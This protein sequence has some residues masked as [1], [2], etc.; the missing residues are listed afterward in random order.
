MKKYKLK[1]IF[2]SAIAVCCIVGCDYDLAPIKSAAAYPPDLNK[3]S[4]FRAFSPDSGGLATQLVL[5]GEN[6][7]TDTSYVK[8]TVNN[9]NAR[10][11]GVNDTI[12]YAVVPARADT[13]YI[14][15]YIGKAEAKKKYTSGKEFIYQFKR[16]VTT[17]VGQHNQE[18]RDDGGYAS[19]KLRRPWFLLTDK[20]G[21]IFFVDE[22]RG[23]SANGALRRAYQ[24]NVETLLQN[25]EGPFQSPTC[26]AFSPRQDTLYITNY[27]YPSDANDVKTDFNII[28]V[29]RDGGF[30]DV[31]GLCKGAKVGTQGIAVHPKTG[32]I[33]F[34]NK[35]DGYIYRYDGPGFNDVTPLFQ[36]N[37]GARETEMRLLFNK[38]GTELY[39]SVRNRHCIQKVP[40]NAVTHEF[41][42]AKMLAGE[43]DVPGYASGK[44]PAARFDNPGQPVLDEDGNLIVPD[45]FN[46]CIRKI[47]PDGDVTLYA[48]LPKQ[49]G[50]GDGLPEQAKFNQPEAITLYTDHTLYVTDRDNHVIRRIAI[51]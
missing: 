41:G 29:T 15:L 10:V 25:T 49:W 21:A 19:S 48:G 27:S 42:D 14:D 43:W 4:V 47:T 12:I 45:K 35:V 18:G 32:E 13:G 22:G 2:L 1:L 3:E 30:M 26:L 33:F 11:I 6:F 46:H 31:R 7:G 9:K 34:N 5:Y 40:Y 20:D 50:F 44:G 39:I 24:G 16:N 8:V 28:Y 37:N 36:L 51:E 17:V 38:E 23:T